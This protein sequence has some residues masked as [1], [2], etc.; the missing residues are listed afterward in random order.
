MSKIIF[1]APLVKEGFN[2][3]FIFI[4]DE[5]NI[6][7]DLKDT[8]QYFYLLIFFIIIIILFYLIYIQK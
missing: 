8:I 2:K 4:M 5:L 6:T 7:K 3:E 1:A